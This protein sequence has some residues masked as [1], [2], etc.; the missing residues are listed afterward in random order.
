MLI[1]VFATPK[2]HTFGDKNN[3]WLFNLSARKPQWSDFQ[4]FWHMS[5]GQWRH[6]SQVMAISRG[7][8]IL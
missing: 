2:R 6:L 1:L 8:L 7:V 4:Q 5:S 3:F